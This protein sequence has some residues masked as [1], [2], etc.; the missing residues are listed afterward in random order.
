M[1]S[2]RQLAGAFQKASTFLEW[3]EAISPAFSSNVANT[4]FGSSADRYLHV[5]AYTSTARC[6]KRSCLTQ[7]FLPSTMPSAQWVADRCFVE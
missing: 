4:A 1:K 3:I 6:L 7:P 2:N 5:C